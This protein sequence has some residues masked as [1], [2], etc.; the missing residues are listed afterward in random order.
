MNPTHKNN[1]EIFTPSEIF[2]VSGAWVSSESLPAVDVIEPVLLD[3][4]FTS[5]KPSRQIR[6]RQNESEKSGFKL[7]QRSSSACFSANSTYISCKYLIC[8]KQPFCKLHCNKV[9]EKNL[10]NYMICIYI[11][12][13]SVNCEKHG[14]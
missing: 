3:T 9:T 12:M 8:S 11:Y 6:C 4:N 7:I 13:R 5:T 2:Q 10:T 1:Y 14:E